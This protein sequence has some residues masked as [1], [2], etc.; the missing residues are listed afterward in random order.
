MSSISIV[1]IP[2]KYNAWDKIPK[3]IRDKFIEETKEDIAAIK[4]VTNMKVLKY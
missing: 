4:I 2:K 1:Y 3:D